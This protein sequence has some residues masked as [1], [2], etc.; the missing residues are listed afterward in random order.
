MTNPFKKFRID[1]LFFRSFFVLIVVVLAC[2]AWTSYN[3]SSKALVKTTSHYQQQLLDELNNE[4]STRLTLI[5]Q[6]SLSTSRDNELIRLLRNLQDEFDRHR[7]ADNV[8]NAMANLTYSIP[9]IQGIDLY[10]ERP[11]RQEENSYIQFWDMRDITREG[12][13]AH[14][15]KNDYA[16]IGEHDIPSFQGYVPV[17]SFGR[18]ILFN[19]TLV[20]VVVIH[21]KAKEIRALLSGHSAESNRIMTD[22]NGREFVKIGES[23]DQLELSQWVNMKTEQSGFVH[24]R[25]NS[26]LEDSLLVYSK[27]GNSSWTLVEMTS[28]NQIIADSLHLAEVIVIIGIAAVILVLLLTLYLSRQF[29]KPINMLVS[30]MSTYSIGGKNMQLPRDYENEFGYLFAGYR[31]QNERIEELY[32]SLERRYEQQRKAEIEALQAN[33]NPH[34]LYNM[35]DQ[36]NWMA[37]EAGHDE[38][39]RI[40]ELMGRMFRIGLSNGDSFI[41]IE[42]ELEHIRCYLEIQQIRWGDGLSYSIEAPS[43]VLELYIPKLTLQPFV[44]NSIV[45]GFNARLTGNVQIRVSCIGNLLRIMIDDDGIG[46]RQVGENQKKRHTGGYGIRNVKERISGYFRDS[47]GVELSEREEGGTRVDICLPL[48]TEPPDN[49]P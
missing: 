30:A 27:L 40:L 32:M 23:L 26:E 47:Y 9:L 35:L 38:L 33:I 20:G 42:K 10:M 43:D 45:H 25:G 19:D 24:I 8:H 36:L 22:S 28:W 16:W 34:F 1:S 12:W 11:F 49:E 29:T 2:I 6:I 7:Q 31:K 4:I 41:T 3:I 18:K 21:V 39:S 46:L 48:L 37:I 14:L 44:E 17:I 15:A 13:D 5:E